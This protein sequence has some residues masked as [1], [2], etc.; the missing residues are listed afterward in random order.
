VPPNLVDTSHARITSGELTPAR[1]E[2]DTEAVHARAVIFATGRLETL[3]G[4]KAWVAQRFRLV[5]DS[6][7]GLQVWVRQ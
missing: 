4:F 6:G 1:V 3:T 2:A 5:D 7:N